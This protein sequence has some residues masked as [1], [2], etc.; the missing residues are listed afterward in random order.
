MFESVD[1]MWTGGGRGKIRYSVRWIESKTYVFIFFFFWRV[2]RF[3]KRGWRNR[4]GRRE[5]RIGW[6]KDK[7]R[8]EQERGVCCDCRFQEEL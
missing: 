5:R 1:E 2:S 6:D 8:I 3:K 4:Q 7:N